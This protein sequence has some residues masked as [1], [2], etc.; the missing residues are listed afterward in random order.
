MRRLL[1]GRAIGWAWA[2]SESDVAQTEPIGLWLSISALA[3]L[4]GVSKQAISKR[5]ERLHAQGLLSRRDGPRS[6]VLINVAEFDRAVG[7]TTDLARATTHADAPAP[8]KEGAALVYSDEQARRVAYLAD[9]AKLDLDERLGKLAPIDAIEAAMVRC[10]EAMVR[11]I[12]Q[13][14]A[15][16]DDLAI[17]V[18]AEGAPGARAALKGFARDLRE[19]LARELKL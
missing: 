6:T 12:D 17:A 10:A 19:T 8:K 9:I 1:E 11:I 14:P 4:R 3:K 7:D 15:R 16:A 13:L 2:M 18:A 5:A